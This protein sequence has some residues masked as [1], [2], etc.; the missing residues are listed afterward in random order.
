MSPPPDH[1]HAPAAGGSKETGR[2]SSLIFKRSSIQPGGRQPGR[3]LVTACL[4][5]LCERLPK[6]TIGAIGLQKRV[7]DQRHLSQWNSEQGQGP[8][9]YSVITNLNLIFPPRVAATPAE[10]AKAALQGTFA[11]KRPSAQHPG[12]AGPWLHVHPNTEGCRCSM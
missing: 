8:I 4:T 9:W 10:E 2:Q 12:R 6:G 5:A 7:A 1:S 11:L 3:Q